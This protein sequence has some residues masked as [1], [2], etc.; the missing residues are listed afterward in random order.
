MHPPVPVTVRQTLEADMFKDK[1]YIPAGTTCALGMAPMMRWG[2]FT[3]QLP[4][5]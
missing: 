2:M 1:Y 4:Q 3:Q 5:T